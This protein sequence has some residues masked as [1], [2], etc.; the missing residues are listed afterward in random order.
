MLVT[1]NLTKRILVNN[2]KIIKISFKGIY[3][4]GSEGNEA[5]NDMCK[6]TEKFIKFE[7]PSGVLFDLLGLNYKFGDAICCLAH[8]LIDKSSNKMKPAC[9]LAKGR[10][11]KALTPLFDKDCAFGIFQIQ[12]FAKEDQ[13]LGYLQERLY[14]KAL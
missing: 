14:T 2:G 9:V 3:P 4:P 7:N 11:L 13:A 1:T 8:T 5:A 10:T 6:K 12:L